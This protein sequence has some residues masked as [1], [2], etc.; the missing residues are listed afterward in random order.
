[1]A[2]SHLSQLSNSCSLSFAKTNQS[3]TIDAR[4][5][6][7]EKRSLQTKVESFIDELKSGSYSVHTEKTHNIFQDLTLKIAQLNQS[8]A[9]V[10][11]FQEAANLSQRLIHLNNALTV[12]F[13]EWQK[14]QTLTETITRTQDH[15]SL[16]SC[17]GSIDIQ[18]CDS[19]SNLGSRTSSISV[20]PSE[21]ARKR[22]DIELAK[23]K[24]DAEFHIQKLE[25]QQALEQVRLNLRK[26]EL[27]VE[28]QRLAVSNPTSV[29]H[30]R[31]PDPIGR[32]RSLPD[33]P[34]IAQGLG[35]SITSGLNHQQTGVH[36]GAAANL[37]ETSILASNEQLNTQRV[38]NHLTTQ[39][40]RFSNTHIVH[41]HFSQ[42]HGSSY[43]PL[44]TPS[45]DRRKEPQPP[46]EAAESHTA[47]SHNGNDMQ[48][49]HAFSAFE[50]EPCIAPGFHDN[51]GLSNLEGH[52]ASLPYQVKPPLNLPPLFDPY[53]ERSYGSFPGY[54]LLLEEAREIRFTGRKLPFIFYYNQITE[55]LN[56][57]PDPRKKM[58]LLRASCQ[59]QARET[60]SALVPPVPGWD[61]NTQIKRAL[62]GLRLRYGCSSFLSEPLVKRVR[63]GQKFAKMDVPA[64][65]QLIS[66]LNDCELYAYAYQQTSSLG[67]TF[68]L[69]VADRL[70]FYSKTRYTDFLTDHW[71][72]PDEPS[73]ESFKQFLNRELKR[74]N[75]TFAQKLLGAS[76]GKNNKLMTLQKVRVHQTKVLPTLGHKELSSTSAARQKQSVCFICSTPTE[77]RRHLLNTCHTYK[78]MTP[79]ERRE[80]IIKA[81]HCINCLSKHHVSDCRLQCKC[82]HCDKHNPQRHTTSL[83][84][85]YLQSSTVGVNVGAA[86]GTIL[87]G[88]SHNCSI[89][90]LPKELANHNATN[91][92]SIKKIQ[93]P[94]T[95]VFTRISAVRVINPATGVST[96][97][98]AQH[99]SGS[100]VTLVSASLADELNLRRGE[101]SV[102]TL[103]TVSGSTT[104][105]F[106]HVSMKVQTLHNGDQFKINKALVMPAWSDESYTLPHHYNL[107]SFSQ[108]DN[109]DVK[110]LPHRSNVDILLGLDN[111][112]LTRVLEERIGEEGEP[113]AIETPIG[114]VASGGKF[115]EDPVSYRSRRIAV[116]RGE[117]NKDQKIL[118]LQ[119]TVRDLS[120]LNEETQPSINDKK[121]EEIVKDSIKVVDGHYEIPVPLKNNVNKLPNN[122]DL[123]A[124][125]AEGLRQK[126]IK[127]PAHLQPL[128]ESMEFLKQ[129]QYIVPADQDS[130]SVNYLPYFLTNQ[131]KP[132]VV[133][134]GSATFEG[135]CVNDSIYSGP[136]LLNLLAHVLAKF[137]MGEY[138]LMGD[139]SKCFF[140]IRL[141]KSQ[142]NLF[143][144]LW[145]KN[146]DVKTGKLEPYKFTR[147]VWG[148]VSSPY[149][150]CLAIRKTAEE[151]YTNASVLTLDTIRNSMY[152]DDLLFSTHTLEEART[153][154]LESIELLASRG[155][156]L[157]KWTSN[158]Q[159][160]SALTE[161][162]KDK[163][164]ASIRTINLQT[165]ADTLP[166][167][168]AVGCVWDAEQDLLKIEFSFDCPKQFTRRNLLSQI[169]RQYDPLGFSAPLLLKGRLI[170]QQL[171]IDGL[172]WDE[173]VGP[174][175][176]KA[177]NDWL[178][179]CMK[180]K[181]I[182]FPR[183]YFANA[184]VSVKDPKECEFE[185]HV[186]SDA[187]NQAYGSVVYLRC[188]VKGIPSTS[189]VFGKSR[190]ILR[191]QQNWPI[192]RK[193]LVAAVMSVKLLDDAFQA[194]RLPKC[195]KHFWSD[196]KVVL[197]WILNPNL[198]L[199]KFIARRIEIIHRLSNLNN[200][201]YC[202]TDANPAD[203]AT[204]PLTKS[205]YTRI[206]FWLKG[207]KFLT[208]RKPTLIELQTYV[209]NA[210]RIVNDRP[211]TSL[212][213][214]P[215][216]Y[217]AISPASILTPSLDPVLP[218]GHPH[219]TD[220]LR[221]DFRYNMA[222]AQ[223]FWERWIKFYLPQ[224][225]RRKKWLKIVD[226]IKVGQLVLVAGPGD[227]NTR[228]KY[229]L[230][231]ISRVL[232]QI[233]KGKAIV[234]LA[235]VKVST[236]N[237]TTSEPQVTEI[238]RDLSKLAPLEFSE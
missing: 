21:L 171:A 74:I 68:I 14:S 139:I 186:F 87:V 159:A 187:S 177:W 93:A 10:L 9:N 78:N 90:S 152:M 32:P 106:S 211:L 156:Q 169:N 84:E 162:S 43:Q 231:R 115:S 225:Q 105:T 76:Q 19:A 148:V 172:S 204:R 103:H 113:H 164:A 200:W 232:P 1:M 158:K 197:Q 160:K 102:V 49:E 179:L 126:M 18:P 189:F 201:K 124:K 79:Q 191:H 199:P 83:H 120:L 238:E 56:R 15:T 28:G 17:T 100:E 221:R 55:L 128:L 233:R 175:C 35:M 2:D 117:T 5:L 190:I 203:V 94:V 143:R 174:Q 207:P 133:Y 64:L 154:A 223:R 235:I 85:L 107:S 23:K 192:G 86:D 26:A 39:N 209:S 4:A 217:N 27:E 220:H 46:V 58:D 147:H 134:D 73:F 52:P 98:Y 166:E 198:R 184:S 30:K 51:P 167:F 95:G 104:S 170:L 155:F 101:T 80:S 237:D 222:L 108:F 138:A 157:V 81:G 226:N 118:E 193:E 53:R 178:K 40:N 36:L 224:L 163:L 213:D 48:H 215:L 122:F 153:V 7:A 136:D 119:Q 41:R 121:A 38:I 3:G 129:N 109:V 202:A 214:D 61:V 140:Q 185:L 112:N 42:G 54:H 227:F 208:Q 67:S 210:T 114:W 44:F 206:E 24:L 33:P 127:N 234:R 70:P 173:E 34:I 65:E 75:T 142:Q 59:D 57:C 161:I 116:Q 145:F 182:S 63:S 71:E 165:E 229:R 72:N 45:V 31:S 50:N 180:W 60:V 123:A 88:D 137:R 16:A 236:I 91:H 151:N 99:D 219:S 194:L 188:I 230:G 144:I 176:A 141:P 125:R 146:N 13:K 66:D 89:P 150:S 82:K 131:S 135:R 92:A 228:G 37:A 110:K 132:R 77:T 216:D 212:S 47:L 11:S 168:K 12:S 22:I 183:W 97:A 62:E 205:F 69:D 29:L 6:R 130:E 196:S 96:L 218:I 149:I 195:T 25:R 111:S 8:A 181:D 20:T